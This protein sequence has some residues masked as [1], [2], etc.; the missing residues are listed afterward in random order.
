VLRRLHRRARGQQRDLVR[1]GRGEGVGVEHR[2]RV[3]GRLDRVDV[4]RV[5]HAQ[6]LLARRGPRLDDAPPLSRHAAAT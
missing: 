6:Q 2:P 1:L 4:R 5:V 3:R